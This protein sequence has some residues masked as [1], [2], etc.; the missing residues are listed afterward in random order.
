MLIRV[1]IEVLL[2]LESEDYNVAI[3]RLQDV[4]NLDPEESLYHFI[5]AGILMTAGRYKEALDAADYG[6]RVSTPH[7]RE[8]L[9]VLRQQIQKRYCA[10]KMEPA[11]KLFREGNYR[12]ARAALH[13]LDRVYR[14]VPLYETFDGYL[15]RLDS[16]L[17][18]F[19]KRKKPANVTPPGSFDD[20]DELYFF[21]LNE[22]IRQAKDLMAAGKF[23]NAGKVLGNAL[24]YCPQF[25]YANYLRAGCLYQGISKQL[26]A[27]KPP[28]VD[29]VISKL[30]QVRDYAKIA[31]VDRDIADGAQKLRSESEKALQFLAKARKE[32]K[33]KAGEA[34]V[35]NGL[36]EEFNA[37]FDGIGEGIQSVS[38]YHNVYDR[39]NSIRT[40]IR[41]AKRKVHGPD[42]RKALDKLTDAVNRHI[43][44]LDSLKPEM[45]ASEAVER[46]FNT[47]NGI[48]NALNKGDFRH[49]VNVRDLPNFFENLKRDVEA[50]RRKYRHIDGAAEALDKLLEAINEV[51]RQ[52]RGY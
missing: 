47:F 6:L 43:G 41:G 19:Q 13:R 35:V 50:D 38:Q 3:K 18:A 52:M 26:T 27:K 24:D 22:D 40:K 32:L 28:G 25:P 5:L 2:Y 51:L 7:E 4:I 10:K 42:G 8:Y 44:Q 17:F 21:L 31:A 37:I 29:E 45:E 16:G 48:I 11:R 12:K 14:D 36:I 30:E 49:I 39:M 9:T 46:H 33:A 23:D 15:A 1:I 20:A 34:K